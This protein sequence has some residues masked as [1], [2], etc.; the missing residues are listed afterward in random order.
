MEYEQPISIGKHEEFPEADVLHPE[1]K[2]ALLDGDIV[3][4][5][6]PAFTA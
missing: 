2:I 6:M 5:G 4:N 3:L 1:T